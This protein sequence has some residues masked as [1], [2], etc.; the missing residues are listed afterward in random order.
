MAQV[1]ELN[2]QGFIE[3]RL[4]SLPGEGRDG[5][6]SYA[7]ASDKAASSAF[8]NA[9]P[10][11]HAVEAAVRF[12]K[13]FGK[14]QLLGSA[15]KV[16]PNQF[17]RV[18]RLAQ[19]CA[20]TLGIATPTVFVVNSPVMNAGTLG[21]NEDSFIMVHSALIDH[22]TDQELLSVIGHECGHI[23]NKH[24]VYLTALNYLSRLVGIVLEWSL[25]PV[26][27]ALKSY[28][29]RAEITCDRAGL[30][31]C[32]DLEVAT[33][34]LTKLA[35]GSSKLYEQ[36]NME[37]FIAQF[38]EGKEGMGSLGE[39]IAL[40]QFAES[41]LYRKHAGLGEGGLSMEEVDRKV[42]EVLKVVP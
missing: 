41:E 42:A 13:A 38:E 28:Q 36:L 8:E 35:L 22:F 6:R 18:H 24:V 30:L 7:Y 19:Q 11:E 17:P 32:K 1:G 14:S 25:P 37:A 10:L 20:E 31:C 21:T 2:F 27:I 5:G 23:H 39:F 29:R 15:V 34:A 3:N 40:R 4:T 33:R 12:F 26:A 16:G 9:K